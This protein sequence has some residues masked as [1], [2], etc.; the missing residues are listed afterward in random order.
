MPFFFNSYYSYII[1]GLQAICV[2]HCVSKGRQNKWIW[3]LVF[4]PLIGCL[5]YIFTEIFT[6]QDIQQVQSGMTSILNPNGS[7]RK[8]EENLRFSDTFTNRLRLADAYLANGNVDKA[9]ELY[10][11]SL[12]GNFTNNEYVLA[13]LIMAYYQKERYEDI[14]PIGKMIYNAPEFPR[15]KAHIL[16]AAAL[17]YLGHTEEA[18]KEFKTMKSRFANYE[19]R[20]YY[21]LLLSGTNRVREARHLF[22]QMLEETSQLSPQERRFNRQWFRLSREELKKLDSQPITG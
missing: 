19:A 2:L 17:G 10:E 16:Y 8:L 9:I 1:I 22:A 12:S 11:S 14:I 21:A 6:R 4:L 15:S 18:E 5:I 7:V 3:L 20:Y 13:H